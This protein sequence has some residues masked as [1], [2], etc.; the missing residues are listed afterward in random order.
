[1]KLKNGLELT[2][3]PAKKEDAQKLLEYL[4]VV[5]GE[6]H[7]LTFGAGGLKIRA[8]DEA[9]FIES[10]ENS[11]MSKM[12]VAKIDGEIVGVS[13][14]DSSPKVRLKHNAEIGVSV[15][16]AYWHLGIASLMMKNLI[17]FAKANGTTKIIHLGVISDNER[18]IALYE[19]FGFEKIGLY[20]NFLKVEDVYYDQILMNKYL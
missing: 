6:S 17:G 18:A 12:F 3:V 10:M 9:K 1:M 14:I 16:K 13:N 20:K 5:G 11:N 4:N 2:I 19:R 15:K 8:E 7:N